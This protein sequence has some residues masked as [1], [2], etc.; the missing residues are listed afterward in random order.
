MGNIKVH[1]LMG[2]PGSGKTTWAKEYYE[3]NHNKK[4]DKR[5]I[6]NIFDL[7][8]ILEDYRMDYDN[9]TMYD[10]IDHAISRN[11][12]SAFR[13][14]QYEFN[15]IGFE[16]IFDGLYTRMEEIDY[17]INELKKAY[18]EFGSHAT[19]DV[20]IH[21]WTPNIE[22]CLSNDAGRREKSSEITIKNATVEY[23]DVN[24]FIEKYGGNFSFCVEV[25][26]V[27]KA[28]DKQK[29]ICKYGK[30]IRSKNWT[31]G[32]MWGDCWGNEGTVSPEPVAPFTELD[33]IL[34]KVCP[35]LSYLEYKVMSD[36]LI[37]QANK[38]SYGYY[39]SYE[40]YSYWYIN[41]EELYDYLYEKNII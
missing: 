40:E 17:T 18:D 3:K 30:E 34:L 21:R 35:N 13:R 33:E 4:G 23:V 26:E 38:T 8:K 31:T 6:I 36:K 28:T 37:H 41:A 24:Q 29:F 15:Q 7:D 10:V 11:M 22:F 27:I 14:Q 19:V 25:H 9:M 12:G 1:I 39:G 32:G 16:Y 20:I 5:I 2:L